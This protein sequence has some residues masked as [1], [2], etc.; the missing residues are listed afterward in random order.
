MINEEDP[1]SPSPPSRGATRRSCIDERADRAQSVALK[2][3]ALE[4]TA[5]SRSN[6]SEL[7]TAT[8]KLALRQKGESPQ[9]KQPQ[10]G[11]SNAG[12]ASI[13]QIFGSVDEVVREDI[14]IDSPHT[15]KSHTTGKITPSNIDHPTVRVSLPT[16]NSLQTQQ[17]PQ[18]AKPTEA[19]LM[20]SMVERERSLVPEAHLDSEV[21]DDI[22]NGHRIH[23]NNDNVAASAGDIHGDDDGDDGDGDRGHDRGGGRSFHAQKLSCSSADTNISV[24]TSNSTDWRRSGQLAPRTAEFFAPIG[25]FLHSSSSSSGYENVQ[26][27]D[28]RNHSNGGKVMSD[29]K[30]DSMSKG[31]QYDRHG[32]GSASNA[33]RSKNSSS[34]TSSSGVNS[35]SSGMHASSSGPPMLKSSSSPRTRAAGDGDSGNGRDTVGSP[36][37][38]SARTHPRPTTT[39][40][41]ISTPA[42]S[43]SRTSNGSSA[44]G[45]SSIRGRNGI[46]SGSNPA[47]TNG[48]TAGRPSRS[49]S[50][51]PR[52]RRYASSS[53][54][55][56]R[57]STPSSSRATTPTSTSTSRLRNCSNGISASIDS[58]LSRLYSTPSSRNLLSH[59]HGLGSGGGAGG[60]AA[61]KGSGG[62]LQRGGTG[63]PCTIAV[64]TG[65]YGASLDMDGSDG[66]NGS[67]EQA[68]S[69]TS[70]THHLH[71]LDPDEIIAPLLAKSPYSKVT[72]ARP[73]EHE[74]RSNFLAPFNFMMMRESGTVLLTDGM[75]IVDYKTLLRQLVLLRLKLAK[76]FREARIEEDAELLTAWRIVHDAEAHAFDLF[77]REKMATDIVQIHASLK[78]MVRKISLVCLEDCINCVN[79][80][81]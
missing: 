52:G 3:A 71:A 73:L 62:G 48:S 5:A 22:G 72:P 4:S 68:G 80:I 55:T 53:P 42:R 15:A 38:G 76:R 39:V 67:P 70:H 7:E 51:S 11:H 37:G 30:G 74:R 31:C 81:D 40:T 77:T 25:T 6:S 1:I 16:Q 75:T 36:R 8:K 34:K 61:A 33:S 59:A 47:S 20:S 2:V 35:R 50:N 26:P 19:F 45:S 66:E 78:N 32:N 46:I 44:R 69:D 60:A 9:T 27:S 28:A 54:S 21:V 24:G 63:K 58:S 65:A 79:S 49:R 43:D 64:V 10:L 29:A 41:S 23:S 13:I 12:G 57:R 14:E 56:S 18:Q 17:Q